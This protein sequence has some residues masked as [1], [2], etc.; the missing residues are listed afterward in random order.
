MTLR[1]DDRSVYGKKVTWRSI[2][3]WMILQC[4]ARHADLRTP[5]PQGKEGVICVKTKQAILIAHYPEH[6]QPGAATTIVEKLA[7]Y[8]VGTGY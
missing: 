5:T 4:N 2:R 8:L 1:T 6:V 7:D 3:I